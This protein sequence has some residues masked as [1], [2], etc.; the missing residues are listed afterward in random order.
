MKL[1]KY[2][3][4]LISVSWLFCAGCKDY[5]RMSFASNSAEETMELVEKHKNEL[6]QINTAYEEKNKYSAYWDIYMFFL[7]YWASPE[8]MNRWYKIWLESAEKSEK[9]GN[10]KKYLNDVSCEALIWFIRTGDRKAIQELPLLVELPLFEEAKKQYLHSSPQEFSNWAKKNIT[11]DI[12]PNSR[13]YANDYFSLLESAALSAN[14]YELAHKANEMF[15]NHVHKHGGE[16]PAVA[17]SNLA[18]Y[19]DKLGSVTEEDKNILTDYYIKYMKDKRL[20]KTFR[21]REE[22]I[23]RVLEKY[24]IVPNISIL[25]DEKH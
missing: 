19:A 21:K 6:D 16:F 9:Y 11:A 3:L 4:L 25:P 8:I 13:F 15:Y 17:A 10:D 2:L 22:C 24:H 1:Y 20:S 23:L 12:V 18:F 7:R 5:S 14:D